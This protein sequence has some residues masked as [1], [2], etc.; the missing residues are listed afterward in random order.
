[1]VLPFIYSTYKN[2]QCISKTTIGWGIR[3]HIILKPLYRLYC[4][5]PHEDYIHLSNIVVTVKGQGH[6]MLTKFGGDITRVF[7][8]SDR[9]VCL[10]HVY[11]TCG[12]PSMP[13]VIMFKWRHQYWPMGFISRVVCIWGEVLSENAINP[14]FT[15]LI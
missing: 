4:N 12:I 5:S 14:M 2:I 9:V 7:C 8:T 10:L 11:R 3:F 1:M 13:N 15:N 6:E